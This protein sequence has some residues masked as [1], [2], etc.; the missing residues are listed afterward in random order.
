MSKNKTT[1]QLWKVLGTGF[2][3]AVTLGGTVGTGILRKPGPI[4]DQ[5]VNPYL[6]VG[7]WI[8]V[9]AY[10]LLGISTVLELSLSIPKAGAWYGY[11]ERAFGRYIGFLVGISSWLGTITAL[12]FGSYTFS[13]YVGILF[14]YFEHQENYVAVGT[15]ALL[16]FFHQLGVVMA[17]KS[18]EWL[19][20]IKALALLGFIILC[21]AFG[22]GGMW[23]EPS[24]SPR[25]LPLWSG[26][27]TALLSIFYAFDGWHTAAYFTEENAD[28][29][30]SMPKSMYIGVIS[31]ALIYLFINISILYV[32]P[33]EDVRHSKLAAADAITWLFGASTGKWITAFLAISIFGILNTQVMF[34]PRV[35]YSMSRDGLFWKKASEVNSVGSPSFA[36]HLTVGMSCLLL[37]M[38]K[39]LNE[40]LS[41]IATFFFVASY[42]SGFSSL[43]KLRQ[44]E[45]QL[46]RPYQA[47]AYPYV[48]SL[49]L[50][51]SVLF[52]MGT[53]I[54]N[55]TS[56]IY[57]LLFIAG[58]YIL[59]RNLFQSNKSDF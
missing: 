54:Q 44:A 56:G 28:P 34:A 29:V 33:L 18:Q 59:F 7:L 41:D 9:A 49:L 30:K 26:I 20:G 42:I 47:W 19:S 58:T 55:P 22:S 12:A 50:F 23:H 4:A 6:I 40:R 35:L 37:L 32:L 15:L 27:M 52:L 51:I 53:L 45:P 36:T 21:F 24:A 46:H 25:G 8:L 43:I 2:G 48:P 10:A 31:V 38:G 57:V 17:G 1:N 16:W 13:E 11:A 39:N 5:L 14:P 3:V